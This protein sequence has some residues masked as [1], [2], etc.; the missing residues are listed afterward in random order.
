MKR[1]VEFGGRRDW[2]VKIVV[3]RGRGRLVESFEED[4]GYF[5]W[6]FRSG[7]SG[8]EVSRWV[9]VMGREEGIVI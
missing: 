1:V 5:R 7:V 9:E 4:N 3:F 2:S 6:R 8:R